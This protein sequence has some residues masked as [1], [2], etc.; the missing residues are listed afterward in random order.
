MVEVVS[1]KQRSNG[2]AKFFVRPLYASIPTISL[3][4]RGKN[5]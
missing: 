3:R 1:N 4:K 5:S 2:H